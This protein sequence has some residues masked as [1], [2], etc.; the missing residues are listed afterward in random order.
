MKKFIILKGITDEDVSL[1]IDSIISIKRD[2]RKNCTVIKTIHQN[3][4]WYV[5]ESVK[6]ITDKINNN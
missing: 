4:E 2:I 5:Q 6:N 3:T 1:T